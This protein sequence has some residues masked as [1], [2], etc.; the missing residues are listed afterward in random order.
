MAVVKKTIMVLLVL[1]LVFTL[2]PA[3]GQK[4]P[5]NSRS[6]ENTITIRADYS[7]Y[8]ELFEIAR[9]IRAASDEEFR[10]PLRMIRCM[11][12]QDTGVYIYQFEADSKPDHVYIEP[13][14]LFVLKTIPAVSATLRIPS[15][16]CDDAG[17][18]WFDISSFTAS[19]RQ[20]DGSQSVTVTITPRSETKV[21]PRYAELVAGENRVGSISSLNFNEKDVCESG[22]FVFYVPAG[23]ES[24]EDALLY[25]EIIQVMELVPADD[26]V[27]YTA[28]PPGSFTITA[29]G[30]ADGEAA[31]V[32]DDQE[33]TDNE[34]GRVT[35]YLPDA[36]DNEPAGEILAYRESPRGFTSEEAERIF[37]AL[38][39]DAE[40]CESKDGVAFGQTGVPSDFQFHEE[41]YYYD[42]NEDYA[43][44]IVMDWT[45]IR[46]ECRKEGT[47]YY[48]WCAN[49]DD[50]TAPSPNNWWSILNLGIC[51][52]A[53]RLWDY[54]SGQA[55]EFTEEETE[56]AE[57]LVDGFLRE[58][59]LDDRW[60]R[61]D[62][63]TT[64][65]ESGNF[66]LVFSLTPEVLEDPVL[67]AE[68]LTG[69]V[70]AGNEIPEPE[71]Y[72][73]VE[74]SNGTIRMISWHDPV[75]RTV[76]AE[77]TVD[78]SEYSLA[79][80]LIQEK[81][82]AQYTREKVEDT[83]GPIPEEMIPEIRVSSVRFAYEKAAV[84][85][86]YQAYSLMPVWILY[87]TCEINGEKTG[88]DV[89]LMTI[90]AI[91]GEWRIPGEPH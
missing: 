83:F 27:S 33:P 58:A 89:P 18:E 74:V 22:E 69:I 72:F 56:Q 6:E 7:A 28:D 52:P 84:A 19:E 16:V 32:A 51:D 25:M 73:S 78:L 29:A 45:V 5:Q 24:G 8:G 80:P 3:C 12:G 31:P 54:A 55:A 87:G 23:S 41:E 35:F 10:N 15:T 77:P 90:N 91:D 40:I 2:L 14:M 62:P 57:G 49:R 68:E 39:G 36:A 1:M 67:Y 13:A 61:T 70:P 86:A 48:M 63:P 71:S 82:T 65:E 11:L 75:E 38:A 43:N 88:E 4:D 9:D 46:G 76:V 50:I 59:G 64:I 81:L 79:L 53:T 20:P 34:A 42:E 85:G 47:P 37:R 21:F 26:S 66:R 60:H 17:K 44:G 30:R